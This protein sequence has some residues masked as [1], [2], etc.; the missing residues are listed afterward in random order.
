MVQII[1]QLLRQG[2]QPLRELW[3]EGGIEEAVFANRNKAYGAYVLRRNEAWYLLTALSI[4]VGGLLSLGWISTKITTAEA[5][6][7]YRTIVLS[8]GFDNAVLP[9]PPPLPKPHYCSFWQMPK[10]APLAEVLAE[11]SVSGFENLPE[12]KPADCTFII[13]APE[14][15]DL[16]QDTFKLPRLSYPKDWVIPE[17]E[18]E[19]SED[20]HQSNFLF[21]SPSEPK[22]LN[23]DE[24]RE[25]ICY[26][27]TTICP[28]PSGVVVFRI[29]V[30]EKGM[31]AEYK[32]LTG[33]PILVKAVE[34]KIPLL[35]FKPASDGQ[36]PIASWVNIPFHYKLLN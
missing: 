14:I 28:G 21:I 20:N 12:P 35:R 8:R 24:I 5:E 11:R 7:E 32:A 13:P 18:E 26:P 2:W 23:L 34:E 29:L 19:I 4:V 16:Q 22:P 25:T 3:Q 31:P 10:P 33:H 27:E 17:I 9:P 36:K 6:Y 15:N 1:I 30:D